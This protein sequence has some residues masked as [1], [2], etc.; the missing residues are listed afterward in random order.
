MF[1][2]ILKEMKEQFYCSE[3]LQSSLE[4]ECNEVNWMSYLKKLHLKIC[5]D[6]CNN[7]CTVWGQSNKFFVAQSIKYVESYLV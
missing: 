6:M 7:N 4:V 5:N 3:I 1:V 2:T